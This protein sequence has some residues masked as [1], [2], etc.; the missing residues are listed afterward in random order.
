MPNP[1]VRFWLK[2]DISP[3]GTRIAIIL[4]MKPNMKGS[5]VVM[6]ND[7]DHK[8]VGIVAGIIGLVVLLL[9][10]VGMALKFL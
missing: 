7:F 9:G 5:Q 3:L 1:Y 10:I 4:G 6:A 8:Y 2:A